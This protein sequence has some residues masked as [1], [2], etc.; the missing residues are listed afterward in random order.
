MA[1][2]A[3]GLICYLQELE[4]Q[5]FSDDWSIQIYSDVSLLPVPRIVSY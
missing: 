5:W 1:F 2:L 4:K 3:F